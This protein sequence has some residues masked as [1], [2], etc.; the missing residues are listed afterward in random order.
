MLAPS[1]LGPAPVMP[2]PAFSPRLMTSSPA[3]LPFGFGTM[4]M[5]PN[6]ELGL[7]CGEGGG[8]PSAQRVVAEFLAQPNQV[9]VCPADVSCPGS[10]LLRPISPPQHVHSSEQS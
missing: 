9:G 8:P 6:P 3:R 5:I 1:M 10:L 7:A 2:L 4:P